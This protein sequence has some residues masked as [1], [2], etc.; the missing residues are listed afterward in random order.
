MKIT[1]DKKKE[2]K[3]K[4]KL[5]GT[6]IIL[7]LNYSQGG[8]RIADKTGTHC[9]SPTKTENKGE[10]Y[11]EWMITNDEIKLLST[12]FEKDKKSFIIEMNKIKKFTEDSKYS[13]RTTILSNKKSLGEFEGFNIYQYKDVFNSFEKILKSGLK[14]RLTFKLGDYGVIAHPHMYVLVPF[15]HKTLQLNNKLGVVKKGAL[16]GP[17]CFGELILNKKD[18]KGIILILAHASKGHR[19]DLIKVMK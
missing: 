1:E 10:K 15:E 4:A 19:D 18:L 12:L 17:G 8:I 3:S 6:K 9:S 7:P 11:V 2:K 5:K 14:V 13:R 16:M